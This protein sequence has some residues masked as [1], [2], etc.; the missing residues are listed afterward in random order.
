VTIA[1]RTRGAPLAAAPV[2]R[3]A[4]REMDPDVPVYEIK[5]MVDVLSDSSWFYGMFAWIVGACGVS[6]L[7]LAAIGLYGVM[8][9]SVGRRREFG[10]RMA[11]G[12]A[13]PRIVALVIRNAALQ[14]AIGV[15][16]GVLLGLALARAVSNMFFGVNPS[17]ALT[18]VAVC[19]VLALISVAAT[20]LPAIRASRV[21]PLEALRID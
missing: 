7:V 8:A 1:V 14:I 6:A 10:I 4:V 16:L 21:Q 18:F 9:F 5:S 17:D 15:F 2:I 12:A 13:G 3:A 19:A 20:L 11:L